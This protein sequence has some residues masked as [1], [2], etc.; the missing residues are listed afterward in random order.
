MRL[1]ASVRYFLLHV[2]EEGQKLKKPA[3][4]DSERDLDE[5]AVLEDNLNHMYESEE[6]D[7]YS[8]HTL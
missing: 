6:L 3:R 7:S 1:Q 5:S 2:G 4:E 8:E